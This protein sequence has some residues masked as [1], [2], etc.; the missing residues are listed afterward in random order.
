MEDWEKKN[1]GLPFLLATAGG[2]GLSPV[3]PGTCGTLVAVALHLAVASVLPRPLDTAVLGV[4][5]LLACGACLA[6]SDWAASHW[7][8]KDPGHMVADEVAGYLL[9]PL[10]FQ[11]AP[12]WPTAIWGFVFFRALDIAKPPPIRQMDRSIPGGWGV[13]A[14]DLGAGIL[15]AVILYLLRWT[16]VLF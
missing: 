3:A 13:L 8:K 15:A 6:T 10:L 12:L 16:G 7:G 9:I 11:G 14:D 1:Q 5:F 2:A 4:L